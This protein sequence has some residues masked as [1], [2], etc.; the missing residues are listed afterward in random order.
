M[1]RVRATKS[2]R[3]DS[4]KS[5]SNLLMERLRAGRVI[6]VVSNQLLLARLIRNK[7]EYEFAGEQ[8]AG[9][10]GYDSLHKGK[11]PLPITRV[12]EL[13]RMTILDQLTANE[14]YLEFVKA[15]MLERAG[16]EQDRPELLAEIEERFE[17]I[18]V[19]QL[20]IELGFD[21]SQESITGLL[22]PLANLPV[23]IYLTTSPYGLLEH[24]LRRAGKIPQT[25]ICNWYNER[26]GLPAPDQE[27]SDVPSIERPIV[28][29]LLG[30]D[31][32]PASLVL[33][34]D[35]HLE[36]LARIGSDTSYQ[37]IPAHLRRRLADSPLLL[38]G[39]QFDSWE[40]KTLLYGVME[41]R[42]QQL[43]SFAVMSE[44]DQQHVALETDW[45][46]K[47]EIEISWGAPDE[48]LRNLIQA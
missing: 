10:L 5:S 9:Y 36:L 18:T 25:L 37:L 20:A 32:K 41:E 19:T 35:D 43:T 26:A 16:S 7:F 40:F 33:T 21:Y 27:P 8:F 23:P 45:A 22:L 38:L 3:V 17:E 30:L 31:E 13:H 42:V 24:A 15:I 39:Y 14:D 1:P 4:T 29:H 44:G 2:S 11:T 12:I 28:F 34:V 46:Q 6:P 47:W 48:F